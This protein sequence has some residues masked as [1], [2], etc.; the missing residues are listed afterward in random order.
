MLAL[1]RPARPDQ[2]AAAAGT[3]GCFFADQGLSDLLTAA[4]RAD[5]VLDRDRE[6]DIPARLHALA[7]ELAPPATAEA[8]GDCDH[9]TAPAA[10]CLPAGGC[11]DGGAPVTALGEPELLGSGTRVRGAGVPE[12]ARSPP[13]PRAWGDAGWL[14]ET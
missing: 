7:A 2:S 10:A 1:D 6:Q 4:W 3:T 9:A 12:G 5:T 13:A 14:A 11:E 8:G